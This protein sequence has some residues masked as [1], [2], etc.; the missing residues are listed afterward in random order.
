MFDIHG[1]FAG[2]EIDQVLVQLQTQLQDYRGM[3]GR[4]LME[5]RRLRAKLPDLQRNLDM[6][7][8]LI[9]KEGE[10]V[11][12]DFQLADHIFVKSSVKDADGVMLWLGADIMLEYELPEA[13]ELLSSQVQKCQEMVA[14]FREA[15]DVV[16]EQITTTEVTIARIYN[17]DVEQRR[18]SK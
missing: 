15:L 6:V 8:L 3:E 12:M 1:I 10:E 4:V 7:K 11:K 9:T 17:Y 18:A 5:L 13:K 2:K 14:E 16:K